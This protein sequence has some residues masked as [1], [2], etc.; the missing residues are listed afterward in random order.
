MLCQKI[1]YKHLFWNKLLYS[2]IEQSIYLSTTLPLTLRLRPRIFRLKHS[3]MYSNV[4]TYLDC[5]LDVKNH[6]LPSYQKLLYELCF[7]IIHLCWCL[8]RCLLRYVYGTK[9]LVNRIRKCILIYIHTWIVLHMP[10]M[11]QHRQ[12]KE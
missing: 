12:I 9:S 5:G 10:K 11:M 3:K 8:I 7:S 6:I 4:P 2:G 1:R